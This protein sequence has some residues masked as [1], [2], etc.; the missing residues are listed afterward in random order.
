ME[1]LINPSVPVRLDG[2]DFILRY[3]AMA[4]IRYAA[5]CEGDLL[6][7]IRRMGGA[8]QDYAR[9]VAAGEF[10]ALAPILETFRDV[11]WAGL[12]DAQPMIERAEV[13]R[14]FGVNDFP[15]LMPAITDAVARGLP[16]AGSVRPTQAAPVATTGRRGS[17]SISGGASPRDSET[18][19]AS[20]SPSSA[21]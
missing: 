7:D 4:F 18:Q 3:R 8:L 11:L 19:A 21:A 1:N 15:S 14:L 6:H 5:D 16:A 2:Q 9:M 17:R 10:A 12:I 20:G 13:A